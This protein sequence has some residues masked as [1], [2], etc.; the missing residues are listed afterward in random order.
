MQDMFQKHLLQNMSFTTSPKKIFTSIVDIIV[1]PQNCRNI[2]E[3]IYTRF[4]TQ[5]KITSYRLFFKIQY[6]SVFGISTN[7]V[8]LH[9]F[10]KICR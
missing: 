6:N 10:L 2:Y 4:S 8:Y 3:I 5:K 7:L 9:G 1:M